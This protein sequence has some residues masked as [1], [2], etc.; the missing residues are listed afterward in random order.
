VLLLLSPKDL[1]KP[2]QE[3]PKEDLVIPQPEVK[4]VKTKEVKKVTKKRAPKKN[5]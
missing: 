2:V 1:V 5:T 4:A 3:T